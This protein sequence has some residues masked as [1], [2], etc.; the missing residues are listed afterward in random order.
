[1]KKV[2]Q[3]AD[4]SEEEDLEE[5]DLEEEDSEEEDLEEEDQE[6]EEKEVEEKEDQEEEEKED[7]EEDQLKDLK[8]IP[9]MMTMFPDME[10]KEPKLDVNK[11]WLFKIELS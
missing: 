2:D 3:K 10:K 1:M 8:M 7:Q 11:R 9:R 5:E 6:V 4:L